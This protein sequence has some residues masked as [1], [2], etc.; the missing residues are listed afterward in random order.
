M[1]LDYLE[2]NQVVE[3]EICGP[4]DK[5]VK[6]ISN[7]YNV[8]LVIKNGKVYIESDDF[9]LKDKLER[10]FKN[11]INLFNF[12]SEITER[13]IIYLLNLIEDNVDDKFNL[14]LKNRKIIGYTFKNKPIYPKTLKQL[15]YLELLDSKDIIFALGKAGTGKTYEAVTYASNLLKNG[16]ISKIILTRPVVEAG[17]SLGYL[18]G[19]LKEKV[20]PYLRP[21]YDALNDNFGYE[22]TELL[23]EKNVIEIAPLAYMRGR[24]LE[25]AVIILDEAQNTTYLQIKMFLT[26][27]GFNSKM[28]I[29]GDESQI[30][31]NYKVE[32]G[33]V[34]ANKILRNIEQ[35]GLIHFESIDVVRHPLVM[36]IID[37]FDD[38]E[39]N[40]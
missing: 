8:K 17:E 29:T 5:N 37:A 16:K 36:K 11:L 18:P 40:R 24:T 7:F 28:I 34:I 1:Y 27:L 32:S 39:N 38:Y 10:L 2:L 12:C 9:I 25:N 6:L 26:R 33:L 15:E 19:D 22:Q 3:K 14:L 23:I 35:I 30:D 20:D 13:D 31:L 4:F 21:L